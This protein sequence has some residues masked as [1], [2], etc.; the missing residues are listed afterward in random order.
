MAHNVEDRVETL[1][2]AAAQHR[3]DEGGAVIRV[4]ELA[5]T[6]E[7]LLVGEREAAAEER[8]GIEAGVVGVRGVRL[9][10]EPVV[11]LGPLGA[12]N[13]QD[14]DAGMGSRGVRDW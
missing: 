14:L 12:D 2:V 9:D 8:E 7:R 6:V 11:A 10:E 5:E 13:N 3:Q 4:E 1:V